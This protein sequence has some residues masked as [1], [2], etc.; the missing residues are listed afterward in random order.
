MEQDDE[1]VEMMGLMQ[2]NDYDNRSEAVECFE[3]NFK[4]LESAERAVVPF[5]AQE[6]ADILARTKP[7]ADNAAEL[8]SSA[9]ALGIDY[10]SRTFAALRIRGLSEPKDARVELNICEAEMLIGRQLDALKSVGE[11][12]QNHSEALEEYEGASKLQRAHIVVVLCICAAILAIVALVV[13]LSV[14]GE[15]KHKQ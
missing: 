2:D 13:G 8:E 6:L 10:L 4:L 11:A 12:R 3:L 7:L 9:L 5:A 14:R 15:G 1:C